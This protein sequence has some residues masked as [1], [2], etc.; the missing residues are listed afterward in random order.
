MLIFCC[1]MNRGGSTL[2]YQIVAEIVESNN[3]GIALG[4]IGSPNRATLKS[5]DNIAHRRDK[6]AVVKCHQY[7]AEARAYIFLNVFD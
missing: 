2:Q 1:G 7:T 3:L 5:L 6:F 4:W